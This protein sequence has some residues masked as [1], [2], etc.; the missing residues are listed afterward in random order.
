MSHPHGPG[1]WLDSPS[2]EECSNDDLL[3]I[4]GQERRREAGR[5]QALL[6]I[7]ARR[8]FPSRGASGRPTEAQRER[9]AELRAQIG[10]CTHTY[11]TAALGQLSLFEVAS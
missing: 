4:A 11:A 7:E 2:F 6:V 8:S 10:P 9:I 3:L 1:E 5:C